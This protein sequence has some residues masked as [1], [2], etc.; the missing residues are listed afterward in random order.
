M[1]FFSAIGSFVSSVC[2]V[3]SSAV[4]AIGSA[5]VTGATKLLEIAGKGIEAVINTIR[6]VGV[7]LGVIQPD[8]DLEKLGEKAMVADKKVEDFDYVS[9]YIQYL[10]DE[11]E[12]DKAKFDKLEDKDKLARKAIGATI[13]SKGI[14]EKKDTIIPMEFW[15][16]TTK[17]GMGQKEIT[18]VIDMFK[19]SSVEN[20]FFDFCKGK[21]GFKEKVKT[22]NLLVEM[23]KELEPDLSNDDIENK[24]INMKNVSKEEGV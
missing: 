16:E 21:L 1:G 17:Q 10:R 23:Y 15:V 13:V 7:A 9:D 5:I 12:V 24:I 6:Q 3:V 20:N 2:S 8:E 11:V 14:E 4:S 19:E 18:G 22:S